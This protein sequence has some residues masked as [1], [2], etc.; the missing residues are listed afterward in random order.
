MKL[1]LIQDYHV[2]GWDKK[3]EPLTCEKT[4]LMPVPDLSYFNASFAYV[5]S[6]GRGRKQQDCFAFLL[7]PVL[8]RSKRMK[9]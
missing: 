8:K 7:K 6:R 2:H 9:A 3:L 5:Q 4:W 1:R